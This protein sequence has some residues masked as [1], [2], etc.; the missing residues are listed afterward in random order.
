MHPMTAVADLQRT[1]FATSRALDFLELRA[2]QSQTGQPADRF[3]DVVVKE[4]IDNALDA[5]EAAR[6]PP[7]ITLTTAA[8]DGLLQLTVADNGGGIPAQ[9]VTRILD[10]DRLVSTNA[11]YRSPTRGLQGNAWKTML[12]IAHVAG[13]GRSL[14]PGLTCDD[15]RPMHQTLS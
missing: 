6:V 9:V 4:L 15:A 5:A 13:P 7:E 10:F 14:N 2:L 1:A 3:G 11:A 8:I 12:G